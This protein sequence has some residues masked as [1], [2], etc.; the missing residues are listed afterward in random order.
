MSTTPILQAAQKTLESLSKL[1]CSETKLQNSEIT[2]NLDTPAEEI[3]SLYQRYQA[4]KG[5]GHFIEFCVLV[6]VNLTGEFVYMSI[7]YV[8]PY[9]INEGY[10]G[11]NIF[12]PEESCEFSD[13]TLFYLGV[14]GLAD[15]ISIVLGLLVVNY[16]GRIKMLR[17][18]AVFP[19]IS[20][21]FLYLCGM[22]EIY[23]LVI[24]LLTRAS[25]CILSWLVFVITGESFPT[26]V[27]AFC[28]CI[29]GGCYSIAS[30]TA[31]FAIHPAYEKS[32][33]LVVIVMQAVLLIT[34]VG[35]FFVK[36]ETS[37][38]QLD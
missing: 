30:V 17:A 31:A 12:I 26:S 15:P 32:A 10:C 29:L 36:R 21:S 20:L 14:V 1:N 34:A 23:V 27:R 24:F 16:I 33:S 4:L 35:S 28:V 2:Q 18:T 8:G 19:L 22:P 6:C 38:A 13:S 3:K 5:T 7:L 9:F 37:G 11:S 25:I